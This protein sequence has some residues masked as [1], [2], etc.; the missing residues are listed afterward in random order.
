MKSMIGVNSRLQKEGIMSKQLTASLL[1]KKE[2]S[3]K[4]VKLAVVLI[5]E[6]KHIKRLYMVNGRQVRSH[7][8]PPRTLLEKCGRDKGKSRRTRK[9]HVSSMILEPKRADQG[10]G[11]SDDYMLFIL[12]VILDITK[13]TGRRNGVIPCSLLN[14]VCQKQSLAFGC[15]SNSIWM[16]MET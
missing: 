2:F 14:S 15:H 11:A 1:T 10:A 8:R 7:L 4:K 9:H 13:I 6:G 3:S 16:L 12:Y 5:H